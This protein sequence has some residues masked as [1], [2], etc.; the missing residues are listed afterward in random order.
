MAKI[1][2]RGCGKM[3][4]H[5]PAAIFSSVYFCPMEDAHYFNSVLEESTNKLWGCHFAVP[6]AVVFSLVAEGE[7]KRVVC[8]LN[9]KTEYQCALLP[10]GDGSFL[11]T[12]N[13]K[14]QTKLGLKI[15]SKVSVGLRKDESEYG[16]PMP[17]ELAELLTQ[18]EE[19]NRLLH[20]LTPGKLRTLLY[21]AGQ[22]KN[23]DVRLQRALAIVEHLK[24]N[25]GK[26]DYKQL[27]V[28]LKERL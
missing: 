2:A 6:Q 23:A 1:E 21:I 24:K 26:I 8:T 9:E 7:S 14:L 25:K 3:L 22:P 15:G 17:E 27:G 10:R 20:A 13:K 28:E 12:V 5:S 18:D 11:I 16:L 19:G 4:C